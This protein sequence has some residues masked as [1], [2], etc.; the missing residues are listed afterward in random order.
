MSLERLNELRQLEKEDPNDP[1]ILYAI[2]LELYKSD[3]FEAAEKQLLKIASI[4][5]DYC[6]V[7]FKLGQWYSESDQVENALNY[8]NKALVIAEKEND[9][10]AVNEIKEAIFMLED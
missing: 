6:P 5:T 4:H 9:K 2:G 7:F 3:S 8:F 10:K 1:F